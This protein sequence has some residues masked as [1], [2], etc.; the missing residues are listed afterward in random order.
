MP[1]AAL[2]IT[3]AKNTTGQIGATGLMHDLQTLYNL[4]YYAV[5]DNAGL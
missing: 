5:P 3:G 2:T 4:L 1:N